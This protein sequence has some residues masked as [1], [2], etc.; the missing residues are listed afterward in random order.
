MTPK[1]QRAARALVAGL[2]GAAII[3]LTLWAHLMIGNFDALAQLGYAG[4]GSRPV[5]GFGLGLDVL[6]FSAVLIPPLALLAAFSGAWPLRALLAALFA[7]GWY[8][9]GEQVAGSFA[10]PSGGGWLPGEAF[11]QLL[12]RPGLTPALWGLALLAYLIVIW[13]FC[14]RPA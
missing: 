5:T 7:L 9:V 12:Y 3:A 6:R 13:R 11:S 1:A 8:W 2:V 14:R 10:S 4:P